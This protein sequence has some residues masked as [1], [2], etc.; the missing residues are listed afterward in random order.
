[1]RLVESSEFFEATKMVGTTSVYEHPNYRYVTLSHC[2]GKPREGFDPLKLTSLTMARFM[3]EGIELRELSNTFR[4]ALL[5]ASKLD[6]VRF[7]WID[8][9]CIRQPLKGGAYDKEEQL[10]DWVEQSRFMDK[11]YRKAYLN[12]SATASIDGDG[13]LFR[14]RTPEYIQD[15]V[16]DVYYPKADGRSA[17]YDTAKCTI[18]SM[19]M[20]QEL[21][22]QA[23]INKRGW[24]LQERLLAPRVLHF[25]H[26]QV[27]WEC[28]EFDDAEISGEALMTDLS[29]LASLGRMKDLSL[30]AGIRS[31]DTRLAGLRDPDAGMQDLYVFELWKRVVEGYSRTELSYASDVFMALAGIARHF[32]RHL[33]SASTECHYVA[34][35]WSRNLESQ[36]LWHVNEEYQLTRF[37]NPAKRF[38]ERAP[39]FSWAAVDTPY[40]I[41]YAD[42]S[43][44]GLPPDL[45]TERVSGDNGMRLRND[46]RGWIGV[47][48]V[49]HPEL[50]GTSM[51]FLDSASEVSE[52]DAEL[53]F[54]VL[55]YSI[56]LIDAENPFGMIKQGQ[57]LLQPRYLRHI[58]LVQLPKE[59]KISHCWCLKP[60][61][62]AEKRRRWEFS[63]NYFDAPDSDTDVFQEEAELF[64]MPAAYGERT[65]LPGDEHL[66]CL[67]LKLEGWTLFPKAHKSS[68]TE[69]RGMYRAFKRFGIAKLSNLM[70]GAA[71]DELKAQ[72]VDEVICLL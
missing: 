33:F 55:G 22:D 20:W 15:D 36:L 10:R 68:R 53:F 59:S 11:V 52:P 24:V 66:Y 3:G 43:D 18:T 31:R 34:G 13:G 61:T 71:Q 60:H 7:V 35:M 58:E 5:F 50:S 65:L 67:L 54:K 44:Y 30:S 12:I 39:S 32:H 40:G 57:M 28:A 8:S 64:A 37:H 72:E 26:D 23:P 29:G 19:S 41:T 6:Q 48:S 45:N 70:D 14:D 1:M 62:G 25:C 21:V 4:H 46:V 38:T 27:A 17:G 63:H 42:V 2:W 47:T 51:E 69:H 16:V 49:K 56:T 9:L